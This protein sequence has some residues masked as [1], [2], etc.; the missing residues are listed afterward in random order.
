MR[1]RPREEKQPVTGQVK[2]VRYVTK[3]VSFPKTLDMKLGDRL[4]FTPDDDPS[5][6]IDMDLFTIETPYFYML[7]NDPADAQILRS[8]FFGFKDGKLYDPN[9]PDIRIRAIPQ[10]INGEEVKLLISDKDYAG[11]RFRQVLPASISELTQSFLPDD[12]ESL[13]SLLSRDIDQVLASRRSIGIDKKTISRNLKRMLSSG[14]KNDYPISDH[15]RISDIRQFLKEAK[16]ANMELQSKYSAEIKDIPEQDIRLLLNTSY[17][18]YLENALKQVP[19]IP[20]K[21]QRPDIAEYDRVNFNQ[22]KNT[23]YSSLYT[24]KQAMDILDQRA[25][26]QANQ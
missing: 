9:Q 22:W 23:L 17:P 26:Q 1:K 2:R 21:N 15:E 24:S 4:R 16:Q 10:S 25:A 20:Q 3:N 18:Q 11:Y 6:S 13:L 12:L 7:L 8:S 14:W 19:Y 5:V